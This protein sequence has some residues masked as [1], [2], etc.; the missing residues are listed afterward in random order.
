MR[1]TFVLPV[2]GDAHHTTRIVELASVGVE[3]QVL[4][5]SREYYPPS[6]LPYSTEELGRIAH[7]KYIGRLAAQLRALPVIRRAIAQAEATYIYGLDLLALFVVA[8]IGR[9]HSPVLIYEI[10]D[11]RERLSGS[12][13]ASRLVRLLE[14]FLLK[15]VDVLV[16][17]SEAYLHSYLRPLQR[18]RVDEEVVI[19]N[20]VRSTVRT[21][22]STPPRGTAITV[23][24]FGLLRCPRSLEI[25]IRATELAN[26]RINVE[27]RG[28]FMLG[29]QQA[30]IMSRIESSERVRFGGSYRNPEDLEQMYARID[31]AWISYPFADADRGNWKWARTNRYYESNFFNTP[32][33]ASSGT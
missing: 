22:I 12:G 8:R 15:R 11:I 5:F 19:E 28:F 32:V 10:P 4:A 13:L 26:G 17:T 25:L 7:G 14:R 21:K 1:I 30:N 3:P 23:G 20:K 6:T 27:L 9:R 18:I 16:V 24:Y 33:I 29:D 31:L 2:V